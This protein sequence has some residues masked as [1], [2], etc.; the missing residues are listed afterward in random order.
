MPPGACDTH[1]HI[2][3]PETAFPLRPD[4]RYTPVA[5]TLEDYRATMRALGLTRGVIVTGSANADNEPTLAAIAAMA[6]DFKGV[7]LVGA[8]VSDGELA[9]LAKGGMTG[10]RVSTVSV[11]GLSPSHLPAMAARVAS[12]GWHVEIHVHRP[13]EIIALAPVLRGLPIPYV[14]DHL[15]Q[16]SPRD[17]SWRDDLRHIT[18]L[19]AADLKAYVNLYGFYHVSDREPP[20]YDDVLPIAQA[21]IAAA[22]DR[23]LWGS[24]WPH[25]STD[26]PVPDDADLLDFLLVAAP[27]AAQRQR[28]LVDNPAR[29]YG[30]PADGNL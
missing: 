24:N 9:R 30:W 1:F 3:Y 5:A 12:L 6:P 16:V 2:Y 4:R 21:L 27:D 20:A 28:I 15:G 19:L 7:A 18:A 14:L 22:P 11:G 23:V 17:G 10:F 29:L 26:V 8:E 25:S 13:A